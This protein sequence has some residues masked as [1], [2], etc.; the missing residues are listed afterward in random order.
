MDIEL[1]HYAI[2]DLPFDA[3]Q[4]EVR[5]AYH[6]AARRFHPDTNQNLAVPD[7]FYKAQ[8]AY[9]VLSSNTQRLDYDQTIPK[10]ET[11]NSGVV[12]KTLQSKSKIG[13]SDQP[14][15]VYVLID[16]S[17][18][19]ISN[20]PVQRPLNL[21]LVLDRSTSMNGERMDMVKDNAIRLVRQLAPEDIISI[22]TFSDRAEVLI[23]PSHPT[24]I[25]MIESKISR[26][27]TGGATEIFQ[28]LEI[29][30]AQVRQNRRPAYMNHLILL[31]DGRTYGD[32]QKCIEM[33][34]VALDEGIGISGL[35]IGN[36][37]NDKFLDEL[38]G[39]SGGVSMYIS[40]PKD[41]R[42]FLEQKYRNLEQV[43]GEQV[44]VQLDESSD[45]KIQY[46]FRIY[47]EPAPLITE[48]PIR[49]GNLQLATKLVMMLEFCVNQ[50]KSSQKEV[51][52]G[53]G[54]V[55]LQIPTRTIPRVRVPLKLSCAVV[56]ESELTDAMPAPI[57]HALSQLTLYRM[58]EKAK[59]ELENGDTVKASRHL[60]YLATHLLSRGE[61]DLAHAVLK[62]ADHIQRSKS[63]SSEGDKRIKYGTRSLL[64]PPGPENKQP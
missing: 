1:S 52:L 56:P 11:E 18:K 55:T 59:D 32:E 62:E 25:N 10:I 4:E 40:A 27:S 24:D 39:I 37:W 44:A 2:L 7:M 5:A 15:L 19:P 9:D 16:I 17:A 43:Y 6:L 50:V 47:P 34:K 48:L 38:A 42:K 36:E 13:K 14:Q 45:N 20:K 35:G 51:I 26:I 29:G 53:Q 63:F 57:V 54:Y 30:I 12:I 61:R 22:V 28:G 64:L 23:P 58:Q 49:A 31:T 60:Q 21:T 46:A 3:S 33:A 8:K 41:L